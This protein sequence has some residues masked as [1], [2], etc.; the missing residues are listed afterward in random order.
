MT[1]EV[2]YARDGHLGRILLNRPTVINALTG[3]MVTSVLAQLRDWA[4]DDAVVAVSIQGAG[5]RGLCAG[6]DVRALRSVVMSGSAGAVQ[7]WAHEYRMNAAIS[8]YPKPLVT[9]MDGIVMGG[10]VGISAHGSLRLVTERSRVAMPETA[11]GFSPD[12]GSMFLLSR[13]PGG[14]GTHLAMTGLSVGG[15]DAVSAGLA[16]ALI[17]SEQIPGIIARLAVGEFLDAGVGS[18]TAVGDLAAERG[19]IDSCYAGNDPVTIL[20]ALRGH[21]A[22]GA[23]H[24]AD[25]LVTRSPLAVAVALEAIRRAGRMDTLAQV[26]DQDLTLGRALA[27]S[28]DF[29]EGVR[30]LLVDR[31]NAPRWRHR[32]LADVDP[33]EVDLLF[34]GGRR[35]AV[36][37]PGGG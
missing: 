34:S 13:A 16:D 14:I 36:E 12:V 4:K 30:A 18:T 35:T 32:S 9:F 1:D 10:G 21:P 24:S 19:W 26:L 15:A 33:A 23:Q 25:V 22:P 2:L 29:V 31:D 7:F 3:H 20:Q 11:I 28:A 27:G 17:A 8:S 6:G 5:E 37:T